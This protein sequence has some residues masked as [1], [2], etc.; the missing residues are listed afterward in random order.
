MK[1][2]NIIRT[3]KRF[4][5]R[6]MHGQLPVIWKTA[7]M[8]IVTDINNK[9]YI[10]FTSGICVTNAGHSNPEI[11]RALF[12]EVTGGL[13]HS[14]TF[15]N[16]P[17][18]DFLEHLI[19]NTPDFIE[20]AFLVSSGTEAT[21]CALKLMKL[22]GRETRKDIIMSFNG[23][24]HGRTL[25][26]E[27]L[28]GKERWIGTWFPEIIHLP[29]PDSKDKF[30]PDVE[31]WLV[32]N[33]P[34]RKI[35]GIMIE[36]Y[37]GWSARFYPKKYI[38]DL[39]MWCRKHKILV[40]FDEIQGG[41]GRTGK[42]FNYMHYDV[43]PDLICV[44]K[45]FSSSLPLAGVLGKKWIL[46]GPETGSMSSTHSANPLCC[47]VGLANFKEIQRILPSV[48]AK[49]KLLHKELKKIFPNFEINGKG[50]LAGIITP[51][52]EYAT[53]VCYKAM[54]KGL[55]LIKTGLNS[56]KIAPPLCITKE[57]L[58]KGL[59]ILKESK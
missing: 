51:T 38:Q 47:A 39:V 40:C 9:K 20:K 27:F 13:M 5:A 34:Y 4:E 1:K 10:D 30:Y 8:D 25:G 36:T 12:E 48:S 57:N 14:Y 52:E 18:A 45:G 31:W 50:L 2:N 15:Y 56:I 58:L 53:K 33:I 46:D 11:C 32:S 26:S 44:G 24:M 35:C 19:K 16:K 22:Y 43:E 29:F 54:K 55:L 28:K 41:M 49:G 21:E 37:Q 17:R 42:L 23:A 6:S 59:N 3:I 7:N